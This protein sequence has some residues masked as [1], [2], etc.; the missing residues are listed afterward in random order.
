MQEYYKIDENITLENIAK[1]RNWVIKGEEP[2]TLRAATYVLSDFR[3]ARI[4]QFTLDEIN[5]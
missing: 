5:S 2:D 1:T 4:G 3:N